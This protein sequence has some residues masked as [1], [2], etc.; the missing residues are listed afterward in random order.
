MWHLTFFG[1]VSLKHRRLPADLVWVAYFNLFAYLACMWTGFKSYDGSYIGSWRQYSHWA[2]SALIFIVWA[3]ETPAVWWK[4]RFVAIG[5]L[6]LVVVYII[7]FLGA[8]L[9][10]LPDTGIPGFGRHWE[11]PLEYVI[12]GAH[13]LIVWYR[14]PRMVEAPSG[15]QE[16]A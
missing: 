3:V 8:E 12:L 4:E 16:L 5:Y 7:L 6:V 9:K 15:A 14:L 1:I 10:F 2:A 11:I 13:L